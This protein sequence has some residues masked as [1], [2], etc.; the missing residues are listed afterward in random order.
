MTGPRRLAIDLAYALR[1]RVLR[2]LRWPT[3]GVKVA[4]FD[5]AGRL[6]LVRNGYGR[7]ELW[8]L[9]GGGVGWRE[10]PE[11]A[12]RRESME[13]VGCRLSALRAIGEYRSRAEGKRDTIHLYSGVTAD[14]PRVDGAEVVEARFFPLDDPP[15][16]TS[17]ATLRRIQELRG[18]RVSDGTW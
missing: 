3:R 7:S 18:A 13:E 17:P 5:G 2:L 16:G 14:P 8:V 9:P 12:V 1:R 10:A 15:P 4:A 11:A 6:L